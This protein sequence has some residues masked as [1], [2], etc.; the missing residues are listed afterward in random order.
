MWRKKIVS[1]AVASMSA[2]PLASFVSVA[3]V[4]AVT[5]SPIVVEYDLDPGKAAAGNLK[6]TNE[7]SSAEV[8]YPV[9][10]DCVAANDQGQPKCMLDGRAT[11][12][13]ISWVSFDK[14]MVALEPGESESVNFNIAVP[15]TAAPG[16]Y[17][18]GLFFSTSS[19]KKTVEGLSTNSA[20]GPLLLLTVNGN[21]TVKGK[22]TDF[23]VKQPS[24][25]SLPVNFAIEF[26]NQGTVHVKPT[27]YVKIDNMFGSTVAVLPI[28]RP[29]NPNDRA[30]SVLPGSSFLFNTAWDKMP[31]V[32]PKRAS[33]FQKEWKNFGF[34]P[35]TATAVLSYGDKLVEQKSVQFW[36]MPYLLILLTG[37]LLVIVVLLVMQYN[38]WIVAN[39]LS[40]RRK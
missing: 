13:L 22:M 1:L 24:G 5:V 7:G 6:I 3:P 4:H 28:N 12:S 23:S 27:G 18:G 33:E 29:E 40:Q 9:A 11:N 10:A 36:V 25:S 20:V 21:V 16:G 35:Y 17:Y 31:G 30:H 32:D 26:A 38:K 15:K 37:L 34:G 39:A 8:F 2:L 19:D 14:K